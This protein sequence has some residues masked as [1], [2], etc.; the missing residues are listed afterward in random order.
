[1]KTRSQEFQ[2]EIEAALANS[3]YPQDR[4][5]HLLYCVG[6]LKTLLAYSALDTWEVRRRIQQ[7][8]DRDQRPR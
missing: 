6:L 1:M 2:E 8:A 5:L 3:P 7:L 4:T